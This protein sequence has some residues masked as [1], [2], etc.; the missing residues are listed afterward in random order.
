MLCYSFIHSRLLFV[1]AA[2][3]NAPICCYDSGVNRP[4]KRR[5]LWRA[6]PADGDGGATFSQGRNSRKIFEGVASYVKNIKIY[7]PINSI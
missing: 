7:S 3:G 4:E 6:F 2:F 5:G 1:Y